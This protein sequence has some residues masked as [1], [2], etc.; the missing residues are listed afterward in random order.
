ME[1]N[2]EQNTEQ[3][4]TP[5]GQEKK[6]QESNSSYAYSYGGQSTGQ[7]DP[8]DAPETESSYEYHYGGQDSGYTQM[9]GG[10]E[11]GSGAACEDVQNIEYTAASGQY[12]NGAGQPYGNA[13]YGQ[14]ENGAG[15]PYDGTSYG[16]YQSGQGQPYGGTS[17]GQYQGGQGQP[18]GGTSYGQYQSGQG[19]P[20]GGTSY[21][22]YQSGQSQPYGNSA[23]QQQGGGNASGQGFSY[24]NT[25]YGQYQSAYTDKDAYQKADSNSGGGFGIASMILGII[26]LAMFCTC[27]NI[28][29]AAAA[30]VFG[31]LQLMKGFRRPGSGPAIAGL[32]TAGL[33]VLAFLATVLLLWGPFQDLYRETL[34]EMQESGYENEFD[35][36]RDHEENGLE[37]W[38]E[39][40]EQY[41]NDRY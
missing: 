18:Y 19:Q 25:Q 28:P 5:E 17:Y 22:Q 21:G 29:I 3:T 10:S 37:D 31:I 36:Y 15:Q 33:S 27:L 24:G 16:Q 11:A 13:S 4:D 12:E 41:R 23:E 9:P 7:P 35:F 6:E 40:L 26:S 38:L 8:A 30:V 32:I 34:R 14:Y 39:Q 2:N 20:Y 1:E